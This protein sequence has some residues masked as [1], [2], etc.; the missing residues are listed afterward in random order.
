MIPMSG[1]ECVKCPLWRAWARRVKPYNEWDLNPDKMK[2]AFELVRAC[3][4][5]CD[6]GECPE[7]VHYEF[8]D[9]TVKRRVKLTQRSI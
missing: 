4:E 1:A 3:E 8:I 2:M 5:A 6:N 7:Y 9:D